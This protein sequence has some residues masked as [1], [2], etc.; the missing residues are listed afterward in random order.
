M[1]DT[2]DDES[3]VTDRME[4][5]IAAMDGDPDACAVLLAQRIGLRL[6]GNPGAMGPQF[7][8]EGQGAPGGCPRR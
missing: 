1:Q 6:I 7:R 5:Q 3:V 2:L 8:H 4:N